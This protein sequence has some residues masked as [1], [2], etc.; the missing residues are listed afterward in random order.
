MRDFTVTLGGEERT[1]RAS[2]NASMAIYEAV[3]DPLE[4]VREA[5]IEST[6]LG[7]GIT[8]K[9]KFTFTIKNVPKIIH[10]GLKEAGEKMTLRDVEEAVFK[11]GFWE[12]KDI[13]ATY[14]AKIVTPG[15]K[16][17]VDEGKSSGELIGQAS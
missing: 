10:I 11:T 9:P 7:A 8:Y 5:N 1:L 6:L 3:G 12:S 17:T 16:E 13:A 15:P 14:I 2:F 4:I